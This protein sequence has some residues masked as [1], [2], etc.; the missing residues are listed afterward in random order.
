MEKRTFDDFLEDA[1]VQQEIEGFEYDEICD[2]GRV[3]VNENYTEHDG[4]FYDA[5]LYRKLYRDFEAYDE[6]SASI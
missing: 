5:T 3:F 4:I 6:Y 1:I 2:G